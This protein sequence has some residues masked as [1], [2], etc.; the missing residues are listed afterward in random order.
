M[1]ETTGGGDPIAEALAKF[2]VRTQPEA[3]QDAP[4][5]GGGIAENTLPERAD[6][7]AQD[8]EALVKDIKEGLDGSD[9]A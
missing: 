1:S 4:T 5:D 2:K 8:A 9:A 7:A 3:L 6:E